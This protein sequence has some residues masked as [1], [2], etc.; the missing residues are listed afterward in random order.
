MLKSALPLGVRR[1]SGRNCAD[2]A[3]VV[4]DDAAAGL[5]RAGITG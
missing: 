1:L 5:K 3:L 2:Y 4:D